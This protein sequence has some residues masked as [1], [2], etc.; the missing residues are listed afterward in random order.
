MLKPNMNPNLCSISSSIVAHTSATNKVI[1]SYVNRKMITS[2]IVSNE[3]LFFKN[4]R[5]KICTL[6]SCLVTLELEGTTMVILMRCLTG[7]V[8]PNAA[9]TSSIMSRMVRASLSLLSRAGFHSP[10]TA[11]DVHLW[12]L[13]SIRQRLNES[14]MIWERQINNE[15]YATA[16]KVL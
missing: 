1:T 3:R 15:R 13:A 12:A 8:R 11:S 2:N 6:A 14:V 7:W 5:K 4:W 9:V 10:G 16:T